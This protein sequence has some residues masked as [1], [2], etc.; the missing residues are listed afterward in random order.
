MKRLL[1]KVKKMER[2]RRDYHLERLGAA[3]CRETGLDPTEVALCNDGDRY[4]YE[5]RDASYTVLLT[6]AQRL[7]AAL[8]AKDEVQ[9][10][11]A[12]EIIK[13]FVKCIQ[14]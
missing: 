13:E 3:F 2:Q 8:E 6:A 14:E 5:H 11:Q 1:K 7:A 4:W 12:Q 9:I 10:A